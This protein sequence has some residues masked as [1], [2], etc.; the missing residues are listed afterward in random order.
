MFRSGRVITWPFSIICGILNHRMPGVCSLCS[1][2]VGDKKGH[3]FLRSLQ[4]H[5]MPLIEAPRVSSVTP[6]GPAQRESVS[7][8][9]Q[10]NQIRLLHIISENTYI[11][12]HEFLFTSIVPVHCK[13]A[14]NGVQNK[15]KSGI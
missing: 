12:G 4:G 13:L 9:M 14:C 7:L 10:I 2:Q 1:G 6:G 11:Q 5:L 8:A 15:I 3:I